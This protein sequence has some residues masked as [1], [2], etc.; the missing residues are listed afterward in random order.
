VI[1]TL[2]GMAAVELLKEG[3]RAGG[4]GPIQE[5]L[6]R[7]RSRGVSAGIG[8]GQRRVD[9]ASRSE[10]TVSCWCLEVSLGMR[11]A[12]ELGRSLAGVCGRETREKGRGMGASACSKTALML[13]K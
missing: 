11:L 2:R 12:S 7:S 8:V 5:D 9:G 13:R 6:G 10:S 3:K 1:I 4:G